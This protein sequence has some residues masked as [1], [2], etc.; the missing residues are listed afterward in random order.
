MINITGA[1]YFQP[2]QEDLQDYEIEKQNS[3]SFL[4]GT[5]ILEFYEK[6]YKEAYKKAQ[7]NDFR[8]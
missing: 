6:R 3:I 4:V 7:K 8:N 5:R 2:W 1:K